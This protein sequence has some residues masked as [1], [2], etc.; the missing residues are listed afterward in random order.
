MNYPARWGEYVEAAKTLKTDIDPKYSVWASRFKAAKSLTG[1]S[2]E[3]QSTSSK[4]AYYLAT[5]ITFVD[6]AVEAFEEASGMKV[7]ARLPL[8]LLK[9]TDRTAPSSRSRRQTTGIPRSLKMA[10]G[11]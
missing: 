11:N 8:R 2:F 6:T 4:D 3:G 1:M 9:N 10:S 5:K 7:G